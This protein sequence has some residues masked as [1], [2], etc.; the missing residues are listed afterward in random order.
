MLLWKN[1]CGARQA[2]RE[3]SREVYCRYLQKYQ[4]LV[5]RLLSS[6]RT[7]RAAKLLQFR[8]QVAKIQSAT[9]RNRFALWKKR[10]STTAAERQR[11]IWCQRQI[12][13]SVLQRLFGNWK[14]LTKILRDR[15]KIK[16]L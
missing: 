12:A 16:R 13:G 8:A 10:Y 14:D 11:E 4:R 2:R 6:Y 7:Q 5:L 9:L 15:S 1:Y 3:K